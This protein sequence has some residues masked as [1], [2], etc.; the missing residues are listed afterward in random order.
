MHF[1]RGRE[2]MTALRYYAE[3]AEAALRHLSPA[4]CMS[5][6]ERAL[7]LLDQ[8]PEGTE[9]QALEIALATLHGVSATHLLGIG[10]PKRRA[11]SSVR[12]SLLADVPRTSDARTPAARRSGSCFVCAREYAEALAVAERAEA[13]SSATNDPVLM[14]V[15]CIVHGEVDQLQGRS[16]A[17]RDM[18]RARSRCRGAAR[19][20]AGRKLRGRSAGHAARAARHPA[21]SPRLGRAGR[22][23]ACE[24]AH[25]RARQLAQPMA[26]LVGHLVRRAVR[27]AARQRRACR[28]SCRRDARARRRVRARARSEWRA[29]GFA[30]GRTPEWAT[31]ARAIAAFARRTKRIRGSGCWREEARSWGMPPRRWCSPATGMRPNT[32]SRKRS[33]SRTRT[34]SACICRSC[35]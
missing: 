26:R 32:N 31:R 22:A 25:A 34:A 29:G 23:R 10:V 1:E 2:P 13:L 6:T 19:L 21:P 15:A 8:A 16:R 4:E 5:L 24:Q 30:V 11:P 3:A 14:L 27:G 9:R 18:D 17:A 28:R 33:K 12:Y 20:R 7:T 35:S